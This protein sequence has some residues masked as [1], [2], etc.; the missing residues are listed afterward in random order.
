MSRCG[1]KLTVN[2]LLNLPSS[3]LEQKPRELTLGQDA[4]VP[5]CNSL[6]RW[7]AR[8]CAACQRAPSARGR[9]SLS[10]GGR[11]SSGALRELTCVPGKPALTPLGSSQLPCWHLLGCLPPFENPS[12]LDC[13][14]SQNLLSWPFCVQG[15]GAVLWAQGRGSAAGGLSGTSAHPPPPR[16]SGVPPGATCTLSLTLIHGPSQHPALGT[17]L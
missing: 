7:P 13:V 15:P 5:R 3:L 16:P 10:A 4:G 1:L 11:P 17:R 14:W 12:P 9:P 8:A 6:G 2:V